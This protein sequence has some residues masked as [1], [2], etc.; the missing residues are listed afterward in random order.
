MSSLRLVLILFLLLTGS[1][2]INMFASEIEQTHWNHDVEGQISEDLSELNQ[3]QHDVKS[4]V[5]E[6]VFKMFSLPFLLYEV[7]KYF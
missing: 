3:V 2:T 6:T 4:T 1:S 5:E 7:Q